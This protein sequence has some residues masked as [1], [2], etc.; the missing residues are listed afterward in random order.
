MPLGPII[1]TPPV[2]WLVPTSGI[3]FIDFGFTLARSKDLPTQWS[4]YDD[5][6]ASPVPL[7]VGRAGADPTGRV[8]YDVDWRKIVEM[9]D[10][11]WIPVP[12][13]RREKGGGYQQGPIN[14]A[15]AYVARLEAPDEHGYDHRV[16][17]AF[18][19]DLAERSAS[20]AYLAP[21]PEDAQ[22]GAEFALAADADRLAWFAGLEWVRDWARA[23]F[24]DMI[25][26]EERARSR[27]EP[28]VDDA[29]LAD[30]MEGPREDVARLMALIE[31]LD[32]L[33]VFPGIRFVDRFTKPTPTPIEVD[34]VLDVGN[35]RTC[36]LLIETHPDQLSADVTQAVKL[37]L[38]D[39]TRPEN[40]YSEPFDSRLEFSRASFGWDDLSFLSG[41]SDAF[42]WPTVARVGAEAQRLSSQR[43]GSEGAS[44]MSSPKRYL[45][46]EDPRRDGWRFNSVTERHEHAAYATGVE[47]TTLVND[48]GEPLH[49]IPPTVPPNDEFAVPVDAG[50][51]RA[52]QPDDLR[53][54][55][56][57]PARL[58]HDE[59]AGAPAAPAQRRPAAPAAADHHDHADRH[60]AGR[61][62]D[63]AQARA[64]RARPRVPVPA[65]GAGRADDGR[66]RRRAGRG[67]GRAAARHRDRVGRGQRHPGGLPLQP[68]R[69]WPIRATRAASSSAPGCRATPPTPRSA[70][71]SGWPR[72]ISAAAPRTSSSPATGSRA[73]APT[74]PCSPSR[75]CARA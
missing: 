72:S 40:V 44:G 29:V 42:A 65:A 58:L 37:Q 8:T 11:V 59:R 64:G 52:Q 16:V 1:K 27:A 15:R 54:G 20:S 38:R 24:V 23:S 21:A 35:S 55:R 67:R 39:L 68:G 28:V 6:K 71:T 56:D 12:F 45:W 41:R 19:T 10:R 51:V 5:P 32:A 70:T 73:R 46:D 26:R 47:F 2:V 30:R 53:A 3:Q 61:A 22:R 4:F 14:W 62:A 34:L 69:A 13:F 48:W 57:L 31:L 74:S 60:A 17:L 7:I 36:G 50:A 25:V 49:M 18:D 66:G 43:R 75:S 63:P 9:L 33:E